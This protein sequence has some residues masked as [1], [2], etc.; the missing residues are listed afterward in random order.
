MIIEEI[1]YQPLL[2]RYGMA[3]SECNKAEI[4]LGHLIFQ[5]KL[6]LK[7]EKILALTLGAKIKEYRKHFGEKEIKLL[8]NLDNLN[9]DRILLAHGF[10]IEQNGKLFIWHNGKLIDLNDPMLDDIYTKA[11]LLSKTLE[12][13]MEPKIIQ[14]YTI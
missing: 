12:G 8:S 9:R 2:A 6:N 7:L 5:K 3:V 14:L 1:K 11:N 10:S 4:F 13:L